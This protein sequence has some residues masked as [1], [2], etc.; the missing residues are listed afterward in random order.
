LLEWTAAREFGLPAQTFIQQYAMPSGRLRAKAAAAGSHRTIVYGQTAAPREIVFFGRLEERKGLRLF[1]NALHLLR[2]E[3]ARRGV[4]VTFL[5]KPERCGGM[6][7]LDYIAQRSAGWQFPVRTMTNLGQPEA[8]QYLLGDGKLAVMPSPLD[9]SPCTVYEA[10][11][12][13]IPFLAARTGGIPELV[14]KSDCEHVLFEYSTESLY[15]ALRNAIEQGGWIAKPAVPHAETRRCWAAMHEQWRSFLPQRESTGA[16]AA[17]VAVI[18]DHPAGARLDLT[19]NSLSACPSVQRFIVINR[20]GEMLPLKTIDMTAEDPEV[21]DAELAEVVEDVVLLIHSGVAVAPH[22]FEAMLQALGTAGVDGLLP[23]CRVTGERHSSVAPPLGGSVAF[24]FFEGVTFTG[25]LLVRRG[26]L[27]A[28]KSGRPFAVESPFMGLADFCV[29]RS[30][31]IWPYPE[32]VTE[33]AEASRIEVKSSLPARIAA[34]D[35]T[36]ANDR[37]YMM[38]AGYGAANHERPAAY[39]RALALAA[40]N[41]GLSPLVR[42]GS[43]GLRRL[44]KWMR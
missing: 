25:A 6:P 30:E 41:L 40:V 22:A 37:Y 3:L 32:V 4:T 16:A 12:G 8:L 36:S 33:R 38:A 15:N 44:R 13:G 34:Y 17:S 28:A 24:S 31:R 43:W 27:A 18:I 29:T 20:G 14:D 5:G 35:D 9:N 26:V 10:L 19:L 7:S 21:L 2:D 23:A 11:G 1:C 39:K 42:I